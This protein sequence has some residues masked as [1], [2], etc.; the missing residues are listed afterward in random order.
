MCTFLV[1]SR[2]FWNRGL[3]IFAFWKKKMVSK[4][5]NFYRLIFQ[6]GWKSDHFFIWGFFFKFVTR[7][8]SKKLQT[9]ML[10]WCTKHQKN[11]AIVKKRKSNYSSLSVFK[12][13]LDIRISHSPLKLR[14]NH[15]H[16]N[17]FPI[18]QENHMISTA[19]RNSLLILSNALR[20]TVLILQMLFNGWMHPVILF[21]TLYLHIF[22]LIISP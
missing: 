13:T 19:H 17:S 22:F 21:I 7:C 16:H 3:G 6:N 11:V 1:S 5:A 20:W 10:D 12:I 9:I 2:R 15:L 4:L 18:N 8:E 14:L